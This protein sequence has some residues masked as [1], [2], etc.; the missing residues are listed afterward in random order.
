MT[1]PCFSGWWLSHPSEKYD[2]VSWDDD[3]PNIWKN[4]KCSKPPTSFVFHTVFFTAPFN[5][6]PAPNQRTSGSSLRP[7][8][9]RQL[10]K[11]EPALNRDSAPTNLGYASIYLLLQRSYPYSVA[12][13]LTSCANF[14]CKTK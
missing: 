2:F 3:I 13:V 14:W 7:K 12:S 5:Y 1:D 11:T 8:T 6:N 10:G 9:C 4:K